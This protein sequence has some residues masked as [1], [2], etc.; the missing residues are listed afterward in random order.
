[1]KQSLIVEELGPVEYE[2]LLVKDGSVEEKVL[3]NPDDIR[4]SVFED[5]GSHSEPT[6]RKTKTSP[7]GRSMCVGAVTMMALCI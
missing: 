6:V 1:M 3:L 5:T 4:S 2:I 7:K